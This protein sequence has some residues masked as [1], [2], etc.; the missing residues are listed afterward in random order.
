MFINVPDDQ[1]V[2]ELLRDRSRADAFAQE[3]ISE[4]PIE[5]GS[6]YSLHVRDRATELSF[7]AGGLKAIELSVGTACLCWWALRVSCATFP[8]ALAMTRKKDMTHEDSDMEMY[9]AGETNEMQVEATVSDVDA[10]VEALATD[11]IQIIQATTADVFH[12]ISTS[13]PL[14]GHVTNSIL[15][16]PIDVLNQDNRCRWFLPHDDLVGAL[17]QIDFASKVV[18]VSMNM[19]EAAIVAVALALAGHPSVS[20]CSFS[21]TSETIPLLPLHA[22][23]DMF[24]PANVGIATEDG[25]FD[26]SN[27][28]A[29]PDEAHDEAHDETL[30]KAYTEAHTVVRPLEETEER[31]IEPEQYQTELFT[32]PSPLSKH[33]FL[34]IARA[35]FQY[36][37]LVLAPCGVLCANP[38]SHIVKSTMLESKLKVG[39]I[40]QEVVETISDL[41]YED[42]HVNESTMA[43][44]SQ[45]WLSDSRDLE[46]S[47]LMQKINELPQTLIT[48][49]A[50]VELGEMP[51]DQTLP[52]IRTMAD[53]VT[54]VLEEKLPWALKPM[55]PQTFPDAAVVSEQRTMTWYPSVVYAL[56][57]TQGKQTQ[58]KQSS[59]QV[60]AKIKAIYEGV[61]AT[62]ADQTLDAVQLQAMADALPDADRAAIAQLNLDTFSS[63]HVVN[64]DVFL[65]ERMTEEAQ[66]TF[67]AKLREGDAASRRQDLGEAVRLYSH[68]MNL[69]PLYHAV[70]V[71][72][73]TKR[74]KI[75][76]KLS[77]PELAAADCALALA[78]APYCVD[79]Y[80]YQGEIAELNRQYESALQN[81]VLAFILGGSRAVEQAEVIERVSKHVGREQAKDVWADML[82]RHDLPSSWLVESYFQSFT[83]DADA[84]ISSWTASKA[85]AQQP[86]ADDDE[87]GAFEWRLLCAIDH[88]RHRRYTEAQSAFSALATTALVGV[89]GEIQSRVIAINMH[90]SFLYVTGDVAAALD[91]INRCLELDPTHVNSIIKKAGFLCELGDF[92]LAD[93]TFQEAATLDDN[94]ADVYLHKGQMELIMGDYASAVAT[95]RRSITRSDTLAVTHISYGMALYKAGSIYQSLDV[96]KTALKQFPTSHEVRLFYGDVLSDRVDYGQAMTH[97]KKA[98]EFSPQCPLPLLNAGRIFVATNDGSH[99]ISHFEEALRVDA[100]CSAAHLDLAQVYFAQGNVDKAFLHF[101]SAIETCR[102]LPEVEDACACR[103]VATMQLQATNILG[104]DLRHML[105]T[106]K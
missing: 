97:L 74:A 19:Q 49:P 17:G 57:Y 103:C 32:M 40:L 51:I 88:R 12:G 58:S 73:L 100:R 15:V 71:D 68:A 70:V 2:L 29:A 55:P 106:K 45:K 62:I 47:R 96:F 53:N 24:V 81:H 89:V 102:F 18:V 44:S 79:A 75:Y 78:I 43:M 83:R 99:A 46:C 34:A 65:D 69:V 60:K 42:F 16:S 6:S 13:A 22:T 28:S 66:R 20:L 27:G 59:L 85:A 5:P 31:I 56:G 21:L 104:V 26:V 64:D 63:H 67:A 84:A 101:D 37:S 93:E 76:I 54:H 7:V 14:A 3:I 90:A 23:S 36:S 10:F 95:L 105:K 35:I 86:S 72:A 8:I 30:L 92:E 94:S 25:S 41:I 50:V 80:A 98:F 87:T 39:P 52:L 77:K 91:M 61:K 4:N 9:S 38:N 82:K 33:K 11:D 1:A 48:P